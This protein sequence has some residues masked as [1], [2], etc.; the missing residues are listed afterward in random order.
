M[1]AY[2]DHEER[3]WR[4]ER[5]TLFVPAS[6]WPMIVKASQS[7][8]DAV[9]ID[10][11]DS[12]TPADK[13][14]GRAN[15]IRALRELDFGP[16]LRI[17]RM[18]GLDTPFAYRDLIEVLEPVGDRVDL[19]LIPKVNG[20]DEIAFVD[21]LIS[22]IVLGRNQTRPIGIEAQIETARGF[23]YAREI[24]AASSRLE[25]L[26]F[27]PGDYAADI[28]APLANIG[29]RDAHDALY[30]GHRWH[31]VMHTIVAAAR[32]NGLRCLDGPFAGLNDPEEL[33]HAARVARAL[34]FSGKQCIHPAQLAVVNQIFSP[35]AHEVAWAEA[36]LRAYG[37][38]VAQGRGAVSLDGKM[39]DAASIRAAQVIV[40]QHRR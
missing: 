37:Q 4:L 1:L 5:S 35:P 24:A 31:A 9:I 20:P 21:R 13:E 3:A 22:Q 32:A 29:E 18:N 28:R 40:E 34:G 23:L 33:D 30:P 2:P 11:E 39:I 26:I 12:V 17:F 27:G 25:A 8:A 38:A 19:V 16:R 6:R 7:Q 14:A 36:V 15:L 10:L